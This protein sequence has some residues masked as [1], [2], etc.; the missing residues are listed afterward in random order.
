MVKLPSPSDLMIPLLTVIKENGGKLD[1][2]EIEFQI[3]KFLGI[4]ESLR[5]QIRSG[6]RTELNY[7]LSWSRS[8][9]K[10]LGYLDKLGK[11]IWSLTRDGQTFLSQ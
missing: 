10:N 6:K 7:L 9:A 8:K 4:P 1:H 2:R 11:G 5:N 3:V